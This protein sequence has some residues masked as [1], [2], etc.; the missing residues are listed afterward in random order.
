MSCGSWL[1]GQ[2]VT[3]ISPALPGKVSGQQLRV[4]V[5]EVVPETKH[6]C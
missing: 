3:S 2:T 1:A 4:S 6:G 5:Q